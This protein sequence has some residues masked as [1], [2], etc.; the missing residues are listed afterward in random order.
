MQ[1]SASFQC[2]GL[3]A[4]NTQRSYG[5]IL[6]CLTWQRW[7]VFMINSTKSSRWSQHCHLP[8]LLEKR[9]LLRAHEL[10]LTGTVYSLPSLARSYSTEMTCS[11]AKP[12]KLDKWL[13]NAVNFRAVCFS[14]LMQ[15]DHWVVV[16]A[17]RL[18]MDNGCLFSPADFG[19]RSQGRVEEVGRTELHS[20]NKHLFVWLAFLLLI[21]N[22]W[23]RSLIK[24][25]FE[26]LRTCVTRVL[27]VINWATRN[28]EQKMKLK[29]GL[30]SYCG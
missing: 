7:L 18:C 26:A 4:E 21:Q 23:N 22:T 20:Q 2:C 6:L 19:C 3:L 17:L 27:L 8:V 1:W 12:F 25:V 14:W 29:S 10:P 5:P 9:A 24:N 15:T 28:C 11:P 13:G 30:A 16:V